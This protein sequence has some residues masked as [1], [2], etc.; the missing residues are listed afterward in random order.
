[1]EAADI[2]CDSLFR[3][4]KNRKECAEKLLELA[5]ELDSV[6]QGSNIAQVV[7]AATSVASISGAVVATFFTG[8]LAFPLLAAATA[9]TVAGT[10]V[11]VTSPLVEAGVSRSTFK[12]ATELIKEDAKVGTR[13]QKQLQDLKDRC[14]GTQLG[15]HA[16]ELECE[17]TTQL[18]CALARRNNTLVPLDFL[19]DFNRAT[20]FR[21]MTPGGLAPANPSRFI[22]QALDLVSF[23]AVITS[24][25]MLSAKEMGKNM[26]QVGIKVAVKA[27]SRVLGVIGLGICL[28]DLID[29]SAELIKG[30][31][32][33]EASELLRDSAREILEGQQ[34]LKEQLEAMQKINQKL[35]TMK[36]LIK[37]LRGYSLSLNED[38][39]KIIDYIM[40]T[41]TD[42]KVV[43]WLQELAH[44]IEFVNLLTFV[45]TILSE[46]EEDEVFKKKLRHVVFVAHGRIVDQFM[47][48]GVLV[49]TPNIID[50]IIYSPWN[51]N[52]DSSAA[53]GIAQGFI[54]VTNREFHNRNGV[55]YEPNPLP[56]HWNSMRGSLHNIPVILL[57]P[58]TP[59]EKA[60]TLF[61]D[62][63]ENRGMEIEDRI[64][65]PYFSPKNLVNVFG[66]IPLFVFIFV[67]SF[68][69]MLS[70][71]TATVH[72]AACLGRAG[73]PPMPAEWRRQYAYT[74]DGTCMTMCMDDRNM[75]S[76][77]FRALRSLFDRNHD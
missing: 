46:E 11:S 49:P 39:Q 58:V 32:F 15:A 57:S 64:I 50:T 40:G 54:Q 1:M 72:L 28:Y 13:I 12:K 31:R 68:I 60:W 10:V 36:N 75:N 17:V 48:A 24:I 16:D 42:N 21:H 22:G 51:C 43:F 3:W 34:K 62:L 30:N 18:M 73:S 2:L 71:K 41:C 76:M 14:G 52:I 6:H 45:K 74:N 19:R 25:L 5:Q 65:I 4:M 20:F 26:G 23:T 27:G 7:G 56:N 33:T 77:L 37:N 35:L 44:Q 70:G 63:C 61:L 55:Y 8:G 67:T 38:G 47:P 69:L 29:K 59:E 53:F 66:E 9:G